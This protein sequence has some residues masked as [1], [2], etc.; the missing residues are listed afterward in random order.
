MAT[1][2]ERLKK[3]IAEDLGVDEVLEGKPSPV[4]VYDAVTWSAII[5]LSI[6]SVAKE[7]LPVSIPD[8]AGGRSRI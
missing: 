8:F 3:V 6:E 4:D 2:L 1:I 7:G 5:P